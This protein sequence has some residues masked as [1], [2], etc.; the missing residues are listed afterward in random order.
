[1][2]LSCVIL[3]A[4]Y[5]SHLGA[6]I[7]VSCS[8][9]VGASLLS[10]V[11]TYMTNGHH[12][13]DGKCFGGKEPIDFVTRTDAEGCSRLSGGDIFTIRPCFFEKCFSCT[14]DLERKTGIT[15][16]PFGRTELSIRASC[17]KFRALASREGPVGPGIQGM[18]NMFDVHDFVF[19]VFLPAFH[20]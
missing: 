15:G 1:M 11:P 5:S 19:N 8:S 20:G 4:G 14:V 18:P 17:R 16:V 13:K 9:H 2:K 3:R 12:W 10:S 6:G 7:T